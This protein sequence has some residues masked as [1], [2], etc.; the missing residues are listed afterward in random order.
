[1]G[2]PIRF[3][4]HELAGAMGDL[5][6]L[7]PLG[8]GMVLVCGLQPAGLFLAVGLFYVATGLY[9]GVTTPVQPMKV[10]GAYAVAM[11][12]GA[13]QIS[14]ATLLVAVL[15]AVVGLSGAVDWIGRHTP[16]AVIRGVQLSTGVLLMAKGVRLMLGTTP[17]QQLQQVAEPYLRFQQI[18][19]LPLGPVIGL[20]GALL[21][22]LL[23]DNRRLP[24]ALAVLL[25][26]ATVGLL[27]GTHTGWA[28]FRLGFTIPDL[29]PLGMP[30]GTELSFALLV[31]VLPQLPMT[32]GNAVIADADLSREYFGPASRRV[33]HRGLCLSMAGGN[34]LSFL[35]GGMPLCHGAGGLAAHYRFGARTAG[36]NVIIG[37]GFI[38]LALL[39]GSHLLA[40]LYLLPLSV[41]GVLLLFAGSQLCLTLQDMQTRRDLFTAFLVLGITLASNLA[42]GFLCGMV[43]AYGLQSGR[44]KV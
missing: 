22:F 6:T 21:T 31:L 34:L 17:L 2:H 5:G 33:T 43:A 11:G 13:H 7:L 23:L 41:M 35:L 12:L 27:F 8:I 3:T 15:L 25:G 38:L 30:G 29:L 16:K 24:A 4:R 42:V 32:L 10:I 19:P 9:F 1:M 20:A 26:G 28:D 18:G 37:I 40:I 44:F 39:C 36:S 14:A